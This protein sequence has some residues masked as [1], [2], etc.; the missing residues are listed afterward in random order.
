MK[1]TYKNK[2]QPTKKKAR[3]NKTLKHKKSRKTRRLKRRSSKRRGGVKPST[4]ENL[5]K[6]LEELEGDPSLH[7]LFINAAYDG[8]IINPKAIVN[9][10]GEGQAYDVTTY[11]L[12]KFREFS[13][14]N[15]LMEIMRRRNHR[16]LRERTLQNRDFIVLRYNHRDLGDA[17]EIFVDRLF[18]IASPYELPYGYS[19]FESDGEFKADSDADSDTDS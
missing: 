19:D 15:I 3:K 14:N 8:F 12:R 1:I 4:S 2:K 9:V 5:M 11:I 7:P 10:Y 16:M 17:Y 6:E 18:E 13:S